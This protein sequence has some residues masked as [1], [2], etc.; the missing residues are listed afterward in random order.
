MLC[1]VMVGALCPESLCIPDLGWLLEGLTKDSEEWPTHQTQISTRH[2]ESWG[3]GRRLI[4]FITF[5]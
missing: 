2:W 3:G 4:L 1:L 5:L